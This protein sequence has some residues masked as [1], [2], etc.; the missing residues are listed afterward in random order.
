MNE[1]ANYFHQ[2]WYITS[3]IIF[4]GL[5]LHLF[6]LFIILVYHILIHFYIFK[7]IIILGSDIHLTFA[8][9]TSHSPPKFESISW[10]KSKMCA[11]ELKRKE[12]KKNMLNDQGQ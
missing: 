1:D 9:T 7:N 10:I 8:P 2:F 11:I 3:N 6:L 5:C 12:K 4:C